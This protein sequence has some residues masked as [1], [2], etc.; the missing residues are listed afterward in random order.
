MLDAL[1]TLARG[2]PQ[3]IVLQTV[4]LKEPADQATVVRA[5]GLDA[6]TARA[7][8]DALL[9]GGQAIPFGSTVLSRS[10]LNRVQV[11]A[12]EYLGQYHRQYP[13]RPGMP[14]EELKSRLRLATRLFNDVLAHLA[15][16]GVVAE[17]GPV[18]RLPGHAVRLDPAQEEVARRLRQRL[19][20]TP[21]APPALPE[22][23]LE[24][25]AGLD[26]ELLAAIVA[27]GEVVRVG[28]DLVFAT[29]TYNE[30]VAAIVDHLKAHGKITVAEARDRF[31]TSRRYVL[32]VL[33]HLDRERITRRLGDE[34]VLAAGPT[35]LTSAV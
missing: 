26:D 13:L 29:S 30:M 34:R 17:A 6:A 21:L 9:A 5:S 20:V 27:L 10:A 16:A 15:A 8:L 28:D 14:R 12:V 32:P 18:V 2:T 35:P 23:R 4:E 11:R 24:V 3:E 31:G 33:E 22:L 1:E 25:G 7:A 19:A